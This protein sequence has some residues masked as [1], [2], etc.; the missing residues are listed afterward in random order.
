MTVAAGHDKLITVAAGHDK[1][2]TVVAAGHDKLITVVA[3]HDEHV[4]PADGVPAGHLQ[5]GGEQQQLYLAH[6]TGQVPPLCPG[7]LM[8]IQVLKGLSHE[9]LLGVWT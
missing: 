4:D 6:H 3:G 2:I 5:P 9:I 7:Q 1:L 8:C